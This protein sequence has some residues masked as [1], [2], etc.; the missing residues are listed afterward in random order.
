MSIARIIILYLLTVP[1]FFAID[2]TWLVFVARGFYKQQL[3][4]LLHT[5]IVWWA[6]TMF[7]LHSSSGY[8]IMQC[9]PRTLREI[10][11][12]RSCWVPALAF[13]PI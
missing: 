8:S 6:A 4:H 3:G 10:G 13:S 1:V 9:F 5:D 12:V 11:H 2:M 7:H